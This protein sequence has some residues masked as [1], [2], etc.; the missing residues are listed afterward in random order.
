LR[1]VK[2]RR[3]SSKR[4]TLAGSLIG[5]EDAERKRIIASIEQLSA[6]NATTGA[7]CACGGAYGTVTPVLWI[8]QVVVARP[9]K[10]VEMGRAGILALE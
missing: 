9:A 4:K 1:F 2:V 10:R 6:S 3:S 8:P 7:A 5:C